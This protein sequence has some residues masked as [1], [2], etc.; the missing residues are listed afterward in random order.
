MS[1]KKVKTKKDIFWKWLGRQNVF[2]VFGVFFLII[3]GS[4]KVY[5]GLFQDEVEDKYEE[6]SPIVTITPKPVFRVDDFDQ[7][8][9]IAITK[10]V[11]PTP[12]QTLSP[13]ADPDP[14]IECTMAK[15]CGGNT[16]RMKR[17]ECS[18][19]VCCLVEPNKYESLPEEE[20]FKK[21]SDYNR[22]QEEEYQKQQQE[23]NETMKKY[24]ETMKKY[25]ENLEIQNEH[26]EQQKAEKKLQYDS[27]VKSAQNKSMVLCSA[28]GTCDSWGYGSPS[29]FV[30]QETE[31]CR[32][33]YGF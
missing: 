13:T 17:S 20:C 29:W 3:Y 22:K 27:C 26:N 31:K 9:T 16:V 18:N 11:S 21:Q 5:A 19:S 7:K 14:M 33:V 12:T 30:Q 10:A 2:L 24:E 6:P 28:N 25:N 15:S 1:R 4:T 23:Y 8:P 32:Q